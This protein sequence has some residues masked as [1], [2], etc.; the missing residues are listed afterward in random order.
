MPNPYAQQFALSEHYKA[1]RNGGTG[2]SAADKKEDFFPDLSERVICPDCKS[3]PPNLTEEFANGDL[4]C[5]E[6]GLVLGNIIDTRSE[7]RYCLVILVLIQSILTR[8]ITL[9]LPY[10]AHILKRGWGRSLACRSI[11]QSTHGWSHGPARYAH[12]LP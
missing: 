10:R 3:D 1:T 7:C 12:Q 5:A 8:S 4:V 9:P 6:C 11:E 2:D